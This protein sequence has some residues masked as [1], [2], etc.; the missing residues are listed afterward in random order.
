V[1]SKALDQGDGGQNVLGGDRK[2]LEISQSA[3]PEAKN[4][5]CC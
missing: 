3:D 2:V 4:K 5:G 1:S